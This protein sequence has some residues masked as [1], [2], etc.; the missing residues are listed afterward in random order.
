MIELSSDPTG[1]IIE[2]GEEEE[3]TPSFPEPPIP[4]GYETTDYRIVITVN[5]SGMSAY[6]IHNTKY[7]VVEYEDHLLSRIINTMQDM[8]AELDKS[9]KKYVPPFLTLVEGSDEDEG[10]PSIH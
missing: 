8:Q 4:T 10:E 5:L 1:G 2:T 3:E 9:V 6:Q 7:G